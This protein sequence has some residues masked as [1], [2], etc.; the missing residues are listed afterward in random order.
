MTHLS[1]SA[2]LLSVA[3]QVKRRH[4]CIRCAR[5]HQHMHEKDIFLEQHISALNESIKSTL[6][7]HNSS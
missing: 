3:V 2:G 6:F 4:L 7:K 1:A 5:I